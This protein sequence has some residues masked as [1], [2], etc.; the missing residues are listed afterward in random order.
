MLDHA[1]GSARYRAAVL[2][3]RAA[4]DI[5]V[6]ADLSGLA[7]D[8]PDPLRKAATE[9]RSM[10]FEDIAVPGS[11]PLRDRMRL[12]VGN[13]VALDLERTQGAPDRDGGD[14]RIDRGVLSVG[15]STDA[16]DAGLLLA[17]DQPRLDVDRWI[18]VL[19]ATALDADEAVHDA[20]VRPTDLATQLSGVDYLTVHAGELA[21]DG[22]ALTKVFLGATRQA[23]NGWLLNVDADQASGSVLWVPTRDSPGRVSAR[24]ARLII[25]ERQKTEVT[26]LLDTPPTNLP[27][28]DILAD[29][30]DLGALHLGQLDLQ[31][32]SPA[33]G[34]GENWLLQKLS[35]SN[36]DGR[37]TGTG[38]WQ[39]DSA[40][41]RVMT[42]KF[43]MNM[44]N[45]GGVLSRFGLPGFVR[46]AP[47][48]LDGE[49][50]WAGSPLA[51]DYPSLSGRL[52]LQTEKG[53]F[54]KVDTPTGG[55]LIGV[56]SMQSIAHRLTG[57]FRDVFSDGF[58]FDSISADAG[59]AGGRLTTDN[60]IMQGVNAKVRI[61]GSVDLQ[62]ETQQLRVVVLPTVNVG[63][64]ALVT[65]FINPAVGLTAFLADLIL[66][67]PIE[68]GL[69][70]DYEVTGTWADPQVNP[71]Q[72]K[73]APPR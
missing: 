7:I 32:L 51:I 63:G 18:R 70:N 71:V 54:L 21:I 43:N 34:H 53:Q 46:N 20:A 62:R 13:D 64:A 61:E 29:Q 22:K 58:A 6:D 27:E 24:L 45:S 2:L 30:F 33:A 14:M 8:L 42:L 50:S 5:I 10:H 49:L 25:P 4:T 68:A 19:G 72:H 35:I 3:R 65:A 55:R 40:G 38:Q 12:A 9:P 36:P 37:L 28:L 26:A 15:A 1:R 69:T 60:F 52:H 57:D 17:I 56:F 39:R 11:Q 23:D 67:R 44:T 66:R 48:K 16:P 73:A 31:A 47:G 41:R 59:V